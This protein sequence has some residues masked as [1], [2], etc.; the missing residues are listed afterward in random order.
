M[1][2]KD[3]TDNN[4]PI[5]YFKGNF[6]FI[7]FSAHGRLIVKQIL[8]FISWNFV[9]CIMDFMLRGFQR[10]FET[11]EQINEK[12]NIALEMVLLVLNG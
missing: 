3:K 1:N 11:T 9:L 4:S 2:Y 10:H 7:F 12:K 8:V 5:Y 6:Y